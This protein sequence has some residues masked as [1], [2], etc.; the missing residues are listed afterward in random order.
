MLAE[1]NLY[2]ATI[3][4]RPDGTRID[5]SIQ[6]TDGPG[7]ETAWPADSV[8]A[9]HTLQVRRSVYQTSFEQPD[10]GWI[11]GVPGDEAES[12]LWV[13][14]DPVG[15]QDEGRWMQPEDDHT[16]GA[17]TLAFITGNAAPGGSSSEN[18]VD[19]GCTT[20]LSPVFDL[21]DEGAAY[22]RYAR[23]FGEGG[24][25]ADDTLRIDV[26]SDGGGSWFPL[27]EVSTPDTLWREVELRVN[28][29]ISLTD[30][31]RFRFR[32][33]DLGSRGVTEAGLDDFS[34]EVFTLRPPP[35]PPPPPPPDRTRLLACVPNPVRES[36]ALR[37]DLS[38]PSH[39]ALRIYD[40]AG[41]RVRTVVSEDL[42]AGT[43][44]RNWDARDDNGHRVG[45]GVY[46]C[47]LRAAGIQQERRLVV[48]R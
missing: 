44:T 24:A 18:D 17:G 8:G 37:F 42:D 27:E 26:S 28:D 12:G 3:Q 21:K 45:S 19:G 41:R 20:L 7:F 5:Y 6:A 32:A 43:Y 25:S 11:A 29:V 13:R 1:G 46:F 47:R 48:I 15:T 23:W 36:T 9:F 14:A 35:T 40:S 39:V 10:S 16:P 2:S 34:L 4:G 30:Q 31:V 22:V 33:C 38:A